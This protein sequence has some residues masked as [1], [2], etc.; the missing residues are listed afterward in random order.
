MTSDDC[1]CLTRWHRERAF[2]VTGR[3]SFHY[4]VPLLVFFL[5]FNQ[6]K[7]SISKKNQQ[8]QNSRLKWLQHDQRNKSC[9]I[10]WSVRCHVPW[11]PCLNKNTEKISLHWRTNVLCTFISK[12]SPSFRACHIQWWPVSWSSCACLILYLC[13]SPLFLWYV[14]LKVWFKFSWNCNRGEAVGHPPVF[15]VSNL[16]LYPIHIQMH[17]IF[18]I[19]CVQLLSLALEF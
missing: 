14:K 4:D 18:P 11:H 7:K 15:N 10:W 8:T 3:S 16:L 9:N 6:Q 19:N 2:A 17:Y 5:I 12:S 1:F 13:S